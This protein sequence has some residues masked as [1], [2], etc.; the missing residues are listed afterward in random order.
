MRDSSNSRLFYPSSFKS[1]LDQN[2]QLTE[3]SNRNINS[4]LSFNFHWKCSVRKTRVLNVLVRRG[5]ANNWN[6]FSLCRNLF[7]FYSYLRALNCL[8]T[9]YSTKITTVKNKAI[10]SKHN[11]F[12]L[13]CLNNADTLEYLL[14]R[15]SHR[16]RHHSFCMQQ[17]ISQKCCNRQFVVRAS[18]AKSLCE[19][20]GDY[21][22]SHHFPNNVLSVH[23][24]DRAI[25]G[26][27]FTLNR[28][29]GG[30]QLSDK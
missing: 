12:S 24:C 21:C 5:K 3:A 26:N 28:G 2:L 30:R 9:T 19:L 1:A 14:Q 8:Q 20:A 11:I 22:D 16:V 6:G 7:F 23:L 15:Q 13:F 18:T 27:L 25:N 10:K 29:E 4:S 17:I